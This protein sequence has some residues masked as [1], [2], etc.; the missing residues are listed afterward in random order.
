MERNLDRAEEENPPYP[1]KR[2]NATEEYMDRD[3]KEFYMIH[4]GGD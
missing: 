4:V 2:S 1:T 3:L